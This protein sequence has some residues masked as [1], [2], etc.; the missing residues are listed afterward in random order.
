MILKLDV[1]PKEKTKRGRPE[2][3][4]PACRGSTGHP[5]AH[6]H[7]GHLAPEAVSFIRGNVPGSLLEMQMLGPPPGPLESSSMS[8]Q[9]LQV[10]SGHL[11][12]KCCSES[13]PA[14]F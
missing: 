7:D 5:R 10:I 6:W 2:P 11:K 4:S 12:E 8:E 9:G 3:A 13:P 1:N 14:E